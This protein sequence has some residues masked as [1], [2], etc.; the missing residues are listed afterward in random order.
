GTLPNSLLFENFNINDLANYFVSK[1]EQ[2][3]SARFEEELQKTNSF[4]HTNGQQLGPVEVLEKPATASRANA[5]GWEAGPIRILEKEAYTHPELQELVQKLFERY[6]IEGCVSLG[7][8]RIAP[9]LFIG[10]ARRGYF[11]Y[12][13]SK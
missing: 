13:R 3:L 10:S 11:N 9:N 2:A 7:T 12:G 5:I 6:K 4:V 8:R 1:H